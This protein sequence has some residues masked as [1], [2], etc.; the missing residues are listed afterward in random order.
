MSGSTP[1]RVGPWS[2]AAATIALSLGAAWVA[3]TG[4]GG[5]AGLDGVGLKLLVMPLLWAIPGAL[6]AT[7]GPR[8]LGWSMIAVAAL[9]A[10]S[11]LAGASLQAGVTSGAPWWIWYADR[12][13]ALI[14]PLTLVVLL[15]LPDGRLPSRRWRPWATAA[16]GLQVLAVA[17][18]ASLQGPAAASD[19]SLP[20]WTGELANPVGLLPGGWGEPLQSWAEVAIQVPFLLVPVAVYGKLRGA[21]GDTRRRVVSVLLA[22]VTFTLLIVVG[23]WLWPAGGDLLDIVAGGLLALTVTASVLRF[24]LGWVDRVVGRLTVFLVLAT[25]LAL[26]YA[27]VVSLASTAGSQLSPVAVGLIAAA[28]TL[29]L[30]PAR[31]RLQDAVD[32]ALYGDSRESARVRRLTEELASSRHQLVTAREEERVLLRRQLHDGLGP[33]LA[34][35]AMQLRDLD[36]IVQEDPDL[37]RSR[38]D[39]LA[40]ATHQA[41]DEVRQMSRQLRP[42]ALDELG[43]VGALEEVAESLGLD[44]VVVSENLGVLPPGPEAAAYRIGREALTNVARHSGCTSAQLTIA[45]HRD[46]VQLEVRDHGA[47]RS[48]PTGVGTLSMRERAHELGGSLSIED[49]DGGGTT[50]RAWLPLPAQGGIR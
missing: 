2:A 8:L 30:A 13:S 7:V 47:G 35:V 25:V 10:L 46:G 42:P 19:S 15:L 12:A 21:H 26:G 45:R 33:T 17:A 44:C 22:V 49:T 37:A 31:A 16:V 34:G 3:G 4:S 28:V 29:A 20:A 43:L 24:R 9:F 18:W 5:A 50:V 27:L 38:L 23:R 40:Q 41:L 14:V 32:W 48:G 39:R 11:A 6:I 1:A 36:Q